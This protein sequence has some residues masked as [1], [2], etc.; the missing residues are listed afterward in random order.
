MA[1]RRQLEVPSADALKA[2]EEGF[3]RET[4]R[5]GMRPPIA[6]VVADA[7]R[8][9][10]PLPHGERAEIARDRSDAETL[11]AARQKGLVAVEVPL[12]EIAVDTLARDRMGI[13]DEEMQELVRSIDAHGLRLPIEVYAQPDGSYALIS[14][15]R[16]LSAYRQ[17]NASYGSVHYATIPAFV[18]APKSSVEAIQAMIEENEVRA[19]ISQYERGRI[20][21]MAVHGGVFSNLDEAVSTLYASASKAKRSKIRSFALIHEELGDMLHFPKS[22]SERQC[23]RLAG[24]LRMGFGDAIRA[25]LETQVIADPDREWA[26]LVPSIEAGEAAGAGEARRDRGGRPKK[27]ASAADPGRDLGR[28]IRMKVGRRADSVS[29]TLSG[30]TLKGDDID[31][32][33][34][35]IEEYFA[36]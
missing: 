30:A 20:A 5:T 28:G 12:G 13:D 19:G 11:R 14:G 10:D 32:V 31:T 9:S 36:D 33:L 3:A 8:L 21:A 25:E 18:R 1:K 23:L 6:D 26:A 16:R 29:I 22:L 7:A 15:F 34:A 35:R 4:S 17:L 27:S 2:L 24:A